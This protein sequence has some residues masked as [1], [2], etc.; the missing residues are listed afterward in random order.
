MHADGSDLALCDGSDLK[1]YLLVGWWGPGA[2]AVVRLTRVYL[3]DFFCS[4]IQ[5]NVL[6]SPY[7]CFISFLYLDL[8][9]LG[10]DAWIGWGSF[11]QAGHLCVFVRVWTGGW[12]WRRGA[13][14]DPQVKYFSDVLRLCFF[15]GSFVSF[16]S[17]VFV[18]LSCLFVAALC[19]LALV[20]D[21]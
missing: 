10:D 20:C 8:Y 21:V 19:A 13:S 6:L 16:V 4:C 3:L 17:C 11:M 18:M 2:L 15:C 7:L 5:F 9:V 14:L 1:I 12:G